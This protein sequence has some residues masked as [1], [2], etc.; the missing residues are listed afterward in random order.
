MVFCLRRLRSCAQRKPIEEK[1]AASRR[2]CLYN[3]AGW[4]AAGPPSNESDLDSTAEGRQVVSLHRAQQEHAQRSYPREKPAGSECEL[5][6]TSRTTRNASHPAVVAVGLHRWR[7]GG[8]RSHQLCTR[9]CGRGESGSPKN[10]A[11]NA[12]G[13]VETRRKAKTGRIA[14]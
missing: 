11:A 14:A 13:Q 4:G 12:D 7:G 9:I 8:T 2:T 6:A 3:S 1:P 10:P 5:E